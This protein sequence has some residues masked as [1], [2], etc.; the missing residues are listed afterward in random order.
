MTDPTILNLL[1]R[2]TGE[3][4]FLV[5]S[6]GILAFILISAL[7]VVAS[8]VGKID[9]GKFFKWMFSSLRKSKKKEN[10]T[11]DD[12]VV[13]NITNTQQQDAEKK[14]EESSPT[15]ESFYNSIM[16]ENPSIW[17]IVI[18]KA[19]KFGS[20]IVQYR[21]ISL[22]R[23]QMNAAEVRTDYIEGILT[24]EYL[25]VLYKK[26]PGASIQDDQ[27]Y[28]IFGEFL[29]G[30]V[31]KNILGILRK[32]F[33]ENHL[34]GYNDEAYK[35]YTVAQ[36]NRLMLNIKLAVNGSIPS[37]LTPGREDI[38]LIL[39]RKSGEIIDIFEDIFIEARSLAYKTEL[40]VKKKE[41]EFD[42]EM[43]RLTGVYNI[44]RTTGVYADP[45]SIP[46]D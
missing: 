28:R 4:V 30:Q 9:L 17:I 46:L 27:N 24:K 12:K 34:T 2:S 8:K 5:G 21:E 33:V 23:S 43:K 1:N 35:E 6:I 42:D 26:N 39:E 31:Y 11:P 19:I 32:V 18:S 29:H 40:I 37:F 45:Y 10:E 41:K 22:I 3:L 16:G 7:M 13:I 25:E 20:E 36:I 38:N 14:K 44:F 15:E